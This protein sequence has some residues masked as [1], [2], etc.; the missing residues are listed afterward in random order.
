MGSLGAGANA[1]AVT[2]ASDPGSVNSVSPVS[3]SSLFSSPS[4]SLQPFILQRS[5]RFLFNYLLFDSL[6]LYVLETE[7]GHDFD[8]D[9]LA[10]TKCFR[11]T[12][13]FVFCYLLH[14]SLTIPSFFMLFIPLTIFV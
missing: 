2:A 3:F 6:K 11:V 8:T 1:I 10:Q 5:P 13:L 12:P 4:T 14:L 9:L 7:A